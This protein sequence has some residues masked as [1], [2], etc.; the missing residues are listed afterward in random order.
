[1]NRN[2][3]K[4]LFE[5]LGGRPGIAERI[6]EVSRQ[7]VERASY[8][9]AVVGAGQIR[10]LAEIAD[11]ESYWGDKQFIGYMAELRIARGA[12]KITFDEFGAIIR[13]LPEIEGE[14]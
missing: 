13:P 4:K 10:L 5:L 7:I 3:A 12:E 9:R 2:D 11:S 14:K 6:I 1:M 8:K